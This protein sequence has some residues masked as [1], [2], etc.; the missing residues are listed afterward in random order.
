MREIAIVISTWLFMVYLAPSHLFGASPGSDEWIKVELQMT[1]IPVDRTESGALFPNH[2]SYPYSAWYHQLKRNAQRL[3]ATIA[4]LTYIQPRSI[5]IF[6]RK[7][8]IQIQGAIRNLQFFRFKDWQDGKLS[9][10]NLKALDFDHMDIQLDPILQ[11]HLREMPGLLDITEDAGNLTS[12]AQATGEPHTQ[13]PFIVAQ[14]PNQ[15][16]E[17]VFFLRIPAYSF[18][19][20]RTI[21][22]V[23]QRF[24]HRSL[25]HC[26]ADLAHLMIP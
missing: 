7:D 3:Q 4:S 8:S 6:W 15:N 18:V 13:F 21:K 19:A 25:G 11:R 1:N 14:R 10:A 26:I 20:I 9:D 17:P 22:S 5:A 23:D 12:Y 24:R 16:S 2:Y